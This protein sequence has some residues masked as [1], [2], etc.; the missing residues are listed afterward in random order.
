MA[1]RILVN[2]FDGSQSWLVQVLLRK[3]HLSILSS[4][5]RQLHPL[6]TLFSMADK[7]QVERKTD[8]LWIV[9]VQIAI[10]IKWKLL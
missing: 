5:S 10:Q 4:F 8:T 7:M 2:S 1:L 3:R 9:L 6:A